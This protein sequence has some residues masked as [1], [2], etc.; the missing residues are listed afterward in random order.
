LGV[1][2]SWLANKVSPTK[3]KQNFKISKFQILFL[4]L[5]NE[6]VELDYEDDCEFEYEFIDKNK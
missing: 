5:K 6:K 3:M 1:G 2:S 4:W